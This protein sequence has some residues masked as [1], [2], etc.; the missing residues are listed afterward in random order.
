MPHERPPSDPVPGLAERYVQERKADPLLP[1][2]LEYAGHGGESV[3]FRVKQKEGREGAHRKVVLK[4]DMY[5]LKRGLMRD[6]FTRWET[7][8][9]A[10]TNEA[11]IREGAR[12][13]AEQEDDTDR[14]EQAIEREE[15]FV[16]ALRRAF[17]AD[18]ILSTRT[19]TRNVPVT[20]EV[21]REILER[22]DLTDLAPA[23]TV[24]VPTIVRYQEILPERA[25]MLKKEAGENPD[26]HSFGFR[27]TER[28]DVPLDEYQRLNRMAFGE[29]EPF[30]AN[31]L[32][33][34]LHVGTVRL[35]GESYVDDELAD[36]L[37]DLVERMM[38]F[39]QT[40]NKMLDMAGGGNIRV[41]KNGEGKWTYLIVD[42]FADNEWTGARDAAHRLT[43][44]AQIASSEVNNLLNGLNYARA[45][46]GMA[47][48]LGIKD[49]LSF[50][51]GGDAEI[52]KQSEA[53][54]HLI[55]SRNNWPDKRMY[56]QE[57]LPAAVGGEKT[58]VRPTS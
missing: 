35:L 23:S 15:Q 7:H 38:E 22:S 8:P 2:E 50:M 55:R 16:K 9:F 56:S 26:M 53:Y 40:S 32:Y 4:A 51:P 48:V 24:S 42:P 47:R 44:S 37:R 49:R 25:R 57:P 6:A 19:V 13:M 18:H 11:R 20:P 58:L 21:A 45:L 33:S 27:Y 12:A 54:L 1:G 39:T 29:K 36:V 31:L 28:F 34:F 14:M 3:V 17:P 43:T 30:D 46:N 5:F 52:D 41:Y 10:T